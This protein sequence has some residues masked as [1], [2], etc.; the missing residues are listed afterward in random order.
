[1]ALYR[2]SDDGVVALLQFYSYGRLR[3]VLRKREPPSC[4]G[5]TTESSYSQSHNALR[6]PERSH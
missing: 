5:A 6:E 1:M 4:F 2:A 3:N